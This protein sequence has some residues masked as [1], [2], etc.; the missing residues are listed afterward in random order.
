MTRSALLVSLATIVAFT[1]PMLAQQNPPQKPAE[2]A[3]EPGIFNL[4]ELVVVVATP[5]APAGIGG[6]VV[7]RQEIWDFDRNS[8]DQAVNTVPGVVSTFDSNGRRNES[9][10]FVRG[11]GRWQVPLTMDGVRIYLPADNRLDFNRFL[12]ADIAAIQIQKGYA[13]V[14]DGPGGMGGAINLVTRKP[15]KKLD[16]EASVWLGGRSSEEGWNGYAMAGTKQEKFY[17]QG[18]VNYSDR[19]YWTLSGGYDPTTGS[20]QQTE[21]RLSS[22]TND[23]RFNAKFGLTPNDTDEYT[24]N[25]TRQNGEKGAPLNVF[26]NPPVPGN[27]YWRWPFWDVQNVSLLSKTQLGTASYVKSRLYYN[28]YKNQVSAFDDIT[29]TTQSAN[30]RFDSPYN[31]H[32]FGISGEAGTTRAANTL[33]A[34]VHYRTDN[35]EEHNINRPTHPTLKNE[36]PIQEQSQYTWSLAFEDTYSINPKV[37]VVGGVSYEDYKITKAEE[38]NTTR[39]LFEYPKGGSDSFNWQG[40]AIWRYADRAQMHASVSDRSRFPVIFELYSTR[41]GTTTPNPD[42]GPERATNYEIGWK[43]VTRNVKIETAV[44][45]SDVRDLIQNVQLADGTGQPQNVGDGRFYGVELAVEAPIGTQLRVGGNYTA[46][47]REIHDALLPNLRATGVPDNKAFLYAA[48]QPIAR[49]TIS[50]SLDLA[51]DRWSDKSTSPV[52]AFPY[53]Q[54][55]A[56]TLFNLTAEYRFARNVEVVAGFKNLSDDYY[57]LSWG[58]PQPGRTFYFKT[59]VGL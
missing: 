6:S 37:D 17:A 28:T 24:V 55:G 3:Q 59:R 36:E 45:Y 40:A 29:Y 27:S 39:G 41:F 19:D 25:Y 8:L 31:D 42:L 14:L 21:R 49:L 47:S 34:A 18:S 56:Y 4:G 50:P 38:F 7:S 30:G 51:D 23:S 26:N 10:I 1:S 52:Q 48:W 20:L 12:T 22:D 53:V 54:T 2:A 32:A 46:I 58:L 44:F 13:S 57:E 33:K 11:F 43:G 15:T 5:E 35:H 16:A 9:D